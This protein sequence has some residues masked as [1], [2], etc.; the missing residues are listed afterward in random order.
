MQTNQARAT[1]LQSLLIPTE[2]VPLLV[3][4]TMVAEVM[5]IGDLALINS[6]EDCVLGVMDWR[7]LRV[8][9][10]S[11]E[12]LVGGSTPRPGPRSKLVVFYPLPG[13]GRTDFFAVLANSD[14]RS[15]LVS[16]DQ[17][18]P[19][20]AAQEDRPCTLSV[21][22]FDGGQACIPDMHAV[23]DAGVIDGN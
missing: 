19:N 20:D 8:P 13:R 2:A 23:R 9:V 10:L 11:F 18:K 14:P 6:A 22:E 3:P 17:L 7:G 4:S 12:A 15:R 5:G 16:A 21:F 1:A